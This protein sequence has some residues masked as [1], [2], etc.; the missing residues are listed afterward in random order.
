M[1][2]GTTSVALISGKGVVSTPGAMSPR[3]DGGGTRKKVVVKFP[4]TNGFQFQ[5]VGVS[6]LL[7]RAALISSPTANH[8]HGGLAKARSSSSSLYDLHMRSFCTAG[9]YIMSVS[10][11]S[12]CA[13]H[14]RAPTR[15]TL[16]SRLS[17]RVTV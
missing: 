15:R 1:T 10:E 11:S 8:S 5:C 13:A 9:A 16:A 2:F 6:L 17:G 7:R 3:P 12:R 4:D 14:R